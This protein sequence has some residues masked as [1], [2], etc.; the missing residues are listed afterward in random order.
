MC[1]RAR[2]FKF[3]PLPPAYLVAPRGEITAEQSKPRPP[4]LHRLVKSQNLRKEKNDDESSRHIIAAAW[5]FDAAPAHGE[6]PWAP[7]ER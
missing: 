5:P 4:L 1:P 3:E 6:N 2:K 7:I